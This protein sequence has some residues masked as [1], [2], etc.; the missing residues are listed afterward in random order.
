MGTGRAHGRLR[1]P[2]PRRP[3]WA[4]A[5]VSGWSL[6]SHLFRLQVHS[7]RR[8]PGKDVG[9]APT[10]VGAVC[11]PDSGRPPPPITSTGASGGHRSGELRASRQP[12][13]SG[14]QRG[15]WSH[16][17]RQNLPSSWTCCVRWATHT[18]SLC[19]SPLPWKWATAADRCRKSKETNCAQAQCRACASWGSDRQPGLGCPPESPAPRRRPLPEWGAGVSSAFSLPPSQR[20]PWPKGQD[21]QRS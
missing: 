7:S 18:A 5:P 10:A 4:S 20:S 15:L 16:T 9:E 6:G 1:G 19:L 2:G 12:V 17:G 8:S 14:G 11:T 13:L 3:G 21:P